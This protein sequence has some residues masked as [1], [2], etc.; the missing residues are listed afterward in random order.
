MLFTAALQFC[1]RF[2]AFSTFFGSIREVVCAIWFIIP[3]KNSKVSCSFAFEA[4]FKQ[5]FNV[6]WNGNGDFQWMTHLHCLGVAGKMDFEPTFK[7]TYINLWSVPV[8]KSP[9]WNVLM[10]LPNKKPGNPQSLA[11][12][13]STV[14]FD[15]ESFEWTSCPIC[16][17]VQCSTHCQLL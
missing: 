8:K 6:W 7:V 10:N 11:K 13:K 3:V 2:K 16:S 17:I 5:F 1:L 15:Y 4:V 9:C 14:D 12:T